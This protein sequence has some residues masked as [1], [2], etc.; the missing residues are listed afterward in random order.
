MGG[1]IDIIILLLLC[2]V[3]I[4]LPTYWNHEIFSNKFYF[5]RIIVIVICL[6]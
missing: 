6:R 2:S 4:N 3:S 5:I 1:I